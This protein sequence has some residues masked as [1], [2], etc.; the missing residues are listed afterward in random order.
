MKQL[1]YFPGLFTPVIALFTPLIFDHIIFK[2]VKVQF[3]KNAVLKGG[4]I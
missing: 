1:F 3:I 4:A 2:N